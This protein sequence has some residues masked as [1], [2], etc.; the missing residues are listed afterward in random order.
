MASVP[1]LVTGM[2]C[3][4]LTALGSIPTASS[5]CRRRRRRRRRER[6]ARPNATRCSEFVSGPA[7]VD[8]DGRAMKESERAFSTWPQRFSV[9]FF[10]LG[11]LSSS[12]AQA[13]GAYMC[14][15][16]GQAVLQSGIWLLLSVQAAG[17][18][19]E[20]EEPRR[21]LLSQYAFWASAMPILVPCLSL[22]LEAS[23]ESAPLSALSSA[24]MV[25][26]V[27]AALSR[28]VSCAAVRHVDRRHS[29]FTLSRFTFGWANCHLRHVTETRALGIDHLPELPLA[30]RSERL[31]AVLQQQRGTR[32]LWRALAA[33]H[34]RPLRLQLFLGIVSTLL[35]FGPQLALLGILRSLEGRGRQGRDDIPSGSWAWVAAL[36]LV[37]LLC[38]FVNS[39]LT[40]TIYAD[41]SIP[42]Y[43]ELTGL[44]F[45]KSMRLKDAATVTQDDPDGRRFGQKQPDDGRRQSNPLSLATVDSRRIA[46]FATLHYLIPTNALKLIVACILLIGLLG[47]K[48]TLAGFAATAVMTPLN[49]RITKR[50][51]HHQKALMRATD[52]RVAELTECLQ[53]I[54]QVK[55]SALEEHWQARIKKKRSA[56]LRCLWATLMHRVALISLWIVCPLVLSTVCLSMYSLLH[57]QLSPSI[58][59]TAMSVFGGLEAALVSL[60]DI[61]SKGVEALVSMRRIDD[62]MTSPERA[63][64]G[65]PGTG[66]I[67]L[68]RATLA[69]STTE[70]RTSRDHAFALRDVTLAFPKGGLSLIAGRTGSGKSLLLASVLGDCEVI[71]GT[72]HVPAPPPISERHDHLATPADW[73]IDSASALVSQTPWIENAT[74][75]DNVVFGLPYH[76][77]RFLEVVW[78]SGLQTD[79]G[80]LPDGEHTDIGANGVN[81]SG[82]QR[83]RIAFARALYS[84]AGI[85]II[86]DIFSALDAYTSRHVYE[87]GLTGKLAH[88]RTRILATHHVDLCLTRSDYC[89]ILDNGSVQHAGAGGELHKSSVFARLVATHGAISHTGAVSSKSEQRVASHACAY[90]N[91]GVA[92]PNKYVQEEERATGSNVVRLYASYLGR[93]KRLHSWIVA[94]AAFFVYTLLFI[95][96]SLWLTVWVRQGDG[97]PSN[98]SSF[99]LTKSS[100][101]R[102]VLQVGVTSQGELSKRDSHPGLYIGVYAGISAATCVLGSL[103]MVLLLSAA[104]ESSKSLFNDMLFAVL[105]APVR[106]HDT[107]PQGRILNRFLADM[108]LLDT[109]LGFDLTLLIGRSFEIVGVAVT[110]ALVSPT[111]VAAAALFLAACGYLSSAYLAAARELKRLENGARSPV[112]EQLRSSM[113]GLATIR[114][115]GRVDDYVHLMHARIND[116]ARVSRNWWLLNSWL[117]FRLG[118]CVAAFSAV[119]AAVVMWAP[120]TVPP[121][122]AGLVL[123]LVLRYNYTVIMVVKLHANVEMDMCAVERVIE[124]TAI[125]MEDQ[126]GECVPAAWPTTGRLEVRDLVV[127]YAPHLSPSIVGVSFTIEPNW[128]VGVVGR[129]GSGKSTLAL[130][131][132][133]ILNA[134][135]GHICL[136][137]RDISR[138]RLRDLR[139]RLAIIPQDPVLFSGSVRSNMDPFD[140]YG[141]AELYRALENVGLLAC[142]EDVTGGSFPSLSSTI[143]EGGLNL[144]QGQRQLLCLARVILSR[145]KML[146]MDEATSAV[147]VE[148]DS[149]IQRSLRCKFGRNGSTLL[150]IAHRLSTVADFDRIL[151]MD[152]GKAVEFGSPWQLMSLPGGHFR[153][154]VENSGERAKLRGM[155]FSRHDR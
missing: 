41:L 120:Q 17:L 81:L 131:L 92:S 129:T 85:L 97:F 111:L 107:V 79:L 88:G 108:S 142:P 83:W 102:P 110:G 98:P 78:A 119:A 63:P 117:T 48:C 24:L 94:L 14:D 89:V 9:A 143:S 154:L 77:S 135:G 43:Q 58:A 116:H 12:L 133:R 26:Q 140:Q 134:S 22:G 136:D 138:V 39:W 121:S 37:M 23:N 106:W 30:A 25:A 122:L 145:T 151:V 150:V 49:S 40:W 7:Y 61:V 20:P 62:F 105:G 15:S 73:I 141:D 45:A 60:P 128:R 36:G 64:H 56:E 74:I 59:F 28:A 53:G 55:F 19:L 10:S 126:G 32:K 57:G 16:L 148:T 46:N 137:G 34:W 130:A 31:L 50:I 152:A 155:M 86:D 127:R 72:V 115:F 118:L 69:W 68:S 95:A 11:G 52:G 47:W 21:F 66:F 99:A 80:L 124:Y 6:V 125:E 123:S 93:N 101:H 91:V 70:Q 13:P 87:H 18:L 65:E 132:F 104:V 84:R 144:S 113:K 33:S 147:D 112:L 1:L 146:V 3:L 4:L 103:R 114:A 100:Q 51:A 8:E 54:R 35:S 76:E 42:I 71:A 27:V 96:R 29:V 90:R 5:V 109:W 38:A 67:T 82:G 44:V 149:L 2:A 153:H 75:R 139:S